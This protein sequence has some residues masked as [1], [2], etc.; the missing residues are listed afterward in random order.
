MLNFRNV[1]RWICFMAWGLKGRKSVDDVHKR[2]GSEPDWQKW[3][4]GRAPGG[5]SKPSQPPLKI[6]LC[7]ELHWTDEVEESVIQLH[8]PCVASKS[9]SRSVSR[10]GSIN[11]PLGAAVQGS[12]FTQWEPLPAPPA[13]GALQ[14][15]AEAWGAGNGQEEPALPFHW[16]AVNFNLSEKDL[17]LWGRQSHLL[18]RSFSAKQPD[19]WHS[20][21]LQLLL[22]LTSFGFLGV[23]R[24]KV[25]HAQSGNVWPTFGLFSQ[26]PKRR[27]SSKM[28]SGYHVTLV[29]V[30]PC[31]T[32]CWAS[33]MTKCVWVPLLVCVSQ[34]LADRWALSKH[35]PGPDAAAAA[36]G[37]HIPHWSLP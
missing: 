34:S 17:C 18:Y 14:G 13:G 31:L 12:G 10:S 33:C 24:R 30:T 32:W 26:R 5:G 21:L 1:R 20:F 35:Q 16:C 23:A 8:H 29:C 2:P 7:T 9:G 4:T 36:A 25:A 15:H 19:C 11:W 3:R 37:T 6:H 22:I 27:S 28:G